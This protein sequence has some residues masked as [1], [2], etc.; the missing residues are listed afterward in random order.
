MAHPLRIQ[1]PH[2][3][4]HVIDRGNNRDPVLSVGKDPA[5]RF[6][7]PEGDLEIYGV[8]FLAP[9]LTNSFSAGER[10]GGSAR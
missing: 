7:C 10:S 8:I 2:A 6:Y 9:L 1:L 3:V 5:G 4:Y